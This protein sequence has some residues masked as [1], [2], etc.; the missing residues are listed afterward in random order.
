VS[1]QGLPDL[2]WGDGAATGLVRGKR[3]MF[4]KNAESLIR[5]AQSG[6]FLGERGPFF[7]FRRLR[8][9]DLD[10]RQKLRWRDM[11]DNP[12]TQVW[13]NTR[14][15]GFLMLDA[16]TE[17]LEVR[18]RAKYRDAFSPGE[19]VSDTSLVRW[20]VVDYSVPEV[21]VHFISESRFP[22]QIIIM[23]HGL[24]L[25]DGGNGIGAGARDPKWTVKEL[26]R[27]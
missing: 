27:I 17:A 3:Y 4:G 15:I 13:I 14:E 23:A 12:E 11:Y 19:T 2:V 25:C 6:E 1:Q 20:M 8:V 18:K 5:Q 10:A 24:S 9:R 7:I 16:E 26:S 21:G 22:E